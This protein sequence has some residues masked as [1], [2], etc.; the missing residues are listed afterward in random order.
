MEEAVAASLMAA[1]S[2]SAADVAAMQAALGIKPSTQCQPVDEAAAPAELA[3]VTPEVGLTW[4]D[5]ASKRGLKAPDV[6]V[7]NNTAPAQAN[8]LLLSL[9][10]GN[11]PFGLTRVDDSGLTSTVDDKVDTTLYE[12]KCP[13]ELP[14]L[15]AHFQTSA[16]TPTPDN[17]KAIRRKVVEL[18][19]ME[20]RHKQ[21]KRQGVRELQAMT[22]KR[23]YYVQE[24]DVQRA[25]RLFLNVLDSGSKANVEGIFRSVFGIHTKKALDSTRLQAIP[26]KALR[27]LESHP[28]IQQ[29]L[30]SSNPSLGI[31]PYRQLNT[32]T[33][34]EI[35]AAIKRMYTGAKEWEQ[36]KAELTSHA[37]KITQ[38]ETALALL[39]QAT[40]SRQPQ[41]STVDISVDK[42]RALEM[43]K[44]GMSY[45][46]I[47]KALGR[48]KQ[49]IHKWLKPSN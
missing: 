36:M 44:Q 13:I 5:F 43:H 17:G 47:G 34:R 42:A 3:R 23:P 24:R 7:A 28:V 9:I 48:S 1:A 18:Q 8:P 32:R 10:E 11:G 37:E 49:A 19:R 12:S 35:T 6:A 21:E 30:S 22:G 33:L 40:P 26:G 45:A 4:A 29:I 31:T 46:A 41:P 15:P 20:D 27:L 2:A 25:L 38:L 39:Q 16:E 14:T